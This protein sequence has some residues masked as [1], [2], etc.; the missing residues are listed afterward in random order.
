MWEENSSKEFVAALRRSGGNPMSLTDDQW[1]L[2]ATL[3]IR[4][5]TEIIWHDMPREKA[6]EHIAFIKEFLYPGMK[7]LY[8]LYS[9]Y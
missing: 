4:A 7:K 8:G 6:E 5:V 2:V 3:Y 1:H 9:L